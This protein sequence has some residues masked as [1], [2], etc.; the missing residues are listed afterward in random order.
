MKYLTYLIPPAL[1]LLFSCQ[2]NKPAKPQAHEEGKIIFTKYCLACHQHDG[3]GVPG[4]YPPLNNTD[5]V[6]GDKNKL[7]GVILHGLEGEITVN[8]QVYKTAMPPHQYLTDQQVADVLTYIRSSF[9]NQAEPVLPAE[10][11]FVRNQPK[12]PVE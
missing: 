4:M 5:W 9:G 2:G 10:V 7:I 1:L 11:A 12:K 3:S 6:M 8:G